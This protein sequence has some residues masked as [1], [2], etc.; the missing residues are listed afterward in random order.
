MIMLTTYCLTKSVALILNFINSVIKS[1]ISIKSSECY[2][3][4]NQERMFSEIII[5]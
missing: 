5:D 1:L 2:I 3:V 4:L